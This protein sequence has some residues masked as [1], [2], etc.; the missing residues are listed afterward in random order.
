MRWSHAR[1]AALAALLLAAGCLGGSSGPA[2][3][4]DESPPARE[5]G[6]RLPADPERLEQAASAPMPGTPRS[7]AEVEGHLG[8][9]A[10]RGLVLAGTAAGLLVYDVSEPANATLVGRLA[11]VH[12]HDVVVKYL[13]NRTVAVVSSLRDGTRI[14]DVSEPEEP[15]ILHHAPDR[16]VDNY[17]DVPGT[18]LLYVGVVSSVRDPR[19]GVL[20]VSDPS[21]PAWDSFPIPET[22]DGEPTTT[23]GCHSFD[24]RPELGLAFCAAGGS[25]FYA[26]GGETLVWNVSSGYAD[27]TWLARIDPPTTM[28]HHSVETSPGGD[29]LFVGG[30][31]WG[32]GNPVRGLRETPAGAQHRIGAQNC[33]G[34]DGGSGRAAP[35]GAVWVYDVSDPSNPV[36]GGY[37]QLSD[38]EVH[39]KCS[40][41][42]GAAIDGDHVAWSWYDGGTVLVDASEPA[43]PRIDDRRPPAN[44]TMDALAHDGH[45]F[46]SSGELQV[47]RVAGGSG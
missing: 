46:A 43:S 37:V 8:L 17:G 30:E 25:M 38:R 36:R 4:D 19:V 34:L 14:V 2:G 40:S 42:F 39:E 23:N 20:D 11:D 5:G 31:N 32:V 7:T 44:S 28:H 45:V 13:A 21:N 29:L 35:T 12:A 9:D 24:V 47:F 33:K 41:H 1:A 10:R 27:P 26:G 22:V 3:P 6:D 15:Q 18:P 16:D